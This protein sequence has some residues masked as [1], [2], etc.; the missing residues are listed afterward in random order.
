[1]AI[2]PISK[3]KYTKN[4]PNERVVDTKIDLNVFFRGSQLVVDGCDY[5]GDTVTLDVSCGTKEGIC[6][7]C[8]EKSS[9]VHSRYLRTLRDL[10]CLG[11]GTVI[12]FNARKFFCN[13]ISCKKK[14]FAEQPGNQIFR[15]RKRTCRC[16]T[17]VYRHSLA[18][19]TIQSACLLNGM[20]IPVSRST[21]LRDLHRLRLPETENLSKGGV[22]DWAFRKG[23]T[24]GTIIVDLESGHVCD[25]LGT[26]READF[27]QWLSSHP[28][29]TA[30]GRDRSTEYSAA[31]KSTGRDIIEVADRFHL[32]KNMSDCITNIISAILF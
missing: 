4:I 8:Q 18:L 30:V 7:Y 3:G 22:D 21:V 6:P 26:R 11:K 14:T 27:S 10:P 28:H 1:M 31:I 12:L 32:L 13:N 2:H 20:G 19:S 9:K 25:M 23:V 29:I 15:Y 16:E 24:Y 17:T 5:E